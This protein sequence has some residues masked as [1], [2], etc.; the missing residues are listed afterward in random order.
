MQY[1]QIKIEGNAGF[2]L[3]GKEGMK[4]RSRVAQK[5]EDGTTAQVLDV[6]TD[7]FI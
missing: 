3:R 1:S 4:C 5:D 6:D 7:M 2:S